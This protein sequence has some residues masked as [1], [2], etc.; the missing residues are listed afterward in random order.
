MITMAIV[1]A[2]NYS[3]KPPTESLPQPEKGICFFELKATNSFILL[4]MTMPP[5]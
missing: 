4:S 5:R 2:I 1:P 3:K